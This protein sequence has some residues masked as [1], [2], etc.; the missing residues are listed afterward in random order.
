MGIRNLVLIGALVVAGCASPFDRYR[1]AA[2][3]ICAPQ[4]GQP[5]YHRCTQDAFHDQYRRYHPDSGP[6]VQSPAESAAAADQF[7]MRALSP[8]PPVIL[9]PW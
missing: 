9:A 1:A 4:L 5:G 2:Q 3:E 7:L 6:I 8:P